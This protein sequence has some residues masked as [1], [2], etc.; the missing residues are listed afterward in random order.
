MEVTKIPKRDI[1]LRTVLKQYFGEVVTALPSDFYLA[2]YNMVRNTLL[3]ITRDG[4]IPEAETCH[5]TTPD[6][7]YMFEFDATRPNG[8][9]LIIYSTMFDTDEENKPAIYKQTE[10]VSKK[11][12]RQFVFSTL[13]PLT[14][15][16]IN[17]KE[18]HTWSIEK[19]ANFMNQLDHVDNL[20]NDGGKIWG[21]FLKFLTERLER[22]WPSKFFCD[23]I[24]P[25]YS[26]EDHISVTN[27]NIDIFYPII[28]GD[29]KKD[30]DHT[31]VLQITTLD[32]EPR[33]LSD[34]KTRPGRPRRT[35]YE[36]RFDVSSD[37]QMLLSILMRRSGCNSSSNVVSVLQ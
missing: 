15:I 30:S 20:R 22:D 4:F 11:Y 26:D 10:M 34:G 3:A 12:I 6:D 32:I 23:H 14:T 33:P 16:I 1:T 29:Y 13:D 2:Q 37:V 27:D 17:N 25:E 19:W 31:F 36:E 9:N 35:E 24:E 8:T 21:M 28:A 5:I 7:K 18:H